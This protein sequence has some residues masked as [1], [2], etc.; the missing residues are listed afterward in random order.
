MWEH[1]SFNE[2]VTKVKTS[3]NPRKT[4]TWTF[5]TGFRTSWQIHANILQLQINVG[6]SEPQVQTE[7]GQQTA[8]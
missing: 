1:R 6:T 5:S 3:V 7:T 8:I 4:E 2:T